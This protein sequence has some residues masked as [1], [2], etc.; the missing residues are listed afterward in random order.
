MRVVLEPF[1]IA[2]F[3][4]YLAGPVVHLLVKRRVPVGLAHLLVLVVS[5]S[6]LALFA[7]LFIG[8]VDALGRK[9]P[10]FQERLKEVAS[11][12]VNGV[13]SDLPFVRRRVRTMMARL[14]LMSPV[15][16]SV[17]G[18]S[19]GLLSF[20][21]SIL[22]ITFYLVFLIH[23]QKSLPVR[24][25]SI[26]GVERAAQIQAVGD[27]INA[28]IARYMYIK[29]LAS[30]FVAGGALLVM[31]AFKLDLALLWA[32]LVFVLHF[33]PYFGSIVGFIFPVALGF[34]QFDEMWKVATMAGLFLLIDNFVGNYWEPKVAGE[35]L[36]VSP[37]VAVLALAFW[38]WIWGTVGMILSVPITVSLRFVLENIPYTRPLAILLSNQPA[39]RKP[40]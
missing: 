39:S 38:G 10:E 2:V 28:S 23:E 36:N 19:S 29:F 6:A 22:L 24:L 5:V 7:A 16:K 35:R 11:T 8:R 30:V 15:T 1:F 27:R 12:T 17:S 26:Y 33:I 13:P 25:V 32:V 3:L 21:S 9:L 40:T 18:F 14:D 31:L 4:F 20:L 34:L 37:L